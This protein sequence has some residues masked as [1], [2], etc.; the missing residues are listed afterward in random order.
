[1][2][3]FAYSVRQSVKFWFS[4]QLINTHQGKLQ[5]NL[6]CQKVNKWGKG[7]SPSAPTTCEMASATL[8]KA[9]KPLALGHL[10]LL[11]L[12]ALLLMLNVVQDSYCTLHGS[13]DHEFSEKAG[14]CQSLAARVS[15]VVTLG[16]RKGG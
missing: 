3:P 8:P 13:G 6:L 11:V 5:F 10:L 1:M 2:F 15:K 4:V 16:R 12:F 14:G 7:H 9:C